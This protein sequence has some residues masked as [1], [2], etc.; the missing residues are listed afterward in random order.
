L[1]QHAILSFVFAVV[2]FIPAGQLAALG[3]MIS[4]MQQGTAAMSFLLG[5]LSVRLCL[6]LCLF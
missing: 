6:S 4:P 2:A 3:S 5:F 1:I